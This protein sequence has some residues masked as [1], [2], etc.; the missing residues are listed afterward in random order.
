MLRVCNVSPSHI[1]STSRGS[2]RALFD[3][4][5]MTKEIARLGLSPNRASS[6]VM[7]YS[8]KAAPL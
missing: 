4:Y 5:V 3:E 6:L 2:Q 1:R 7:T 8:S